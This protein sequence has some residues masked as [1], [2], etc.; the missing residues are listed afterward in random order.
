MEKDQRIEKRIKEKRKLKG[1]LSYMV[2]AGDRHRRS[3]EAGDRRRRRLNDVAR[4][5]ADELWRQK[6]SIY[7]SEGR[8]TRF[9]ARIEARFVKPHRRRQDQS[10]QTR[11]RNDGFNMDPSSLERFLATQKTVEL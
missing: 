11:K 10:A 1:Y 8:E 5:D 4:V 9:L 2:E 3:F 6:R 7:T